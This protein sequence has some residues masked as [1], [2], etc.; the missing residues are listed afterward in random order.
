MM[1]ENPNLCESN[2]VNEDRRSR[3][4]K[5]GITQDGPL[6]KDIG[7]GVRTNAIPPNRSQTYTTC[8]HYVRR[9]KGA[10]EEEDWLMLFLGSCKSTRSFYETLHPYGGCFTPSGE[11]W[12]DI[13]EP[14]LSIHILLQIEK[15]GTNQLLYHM[16]RP[17]KDLNNKARIIPCKLKKQEAFQN[18]DIL[19]TVGKPEESLF[20]SEGNISC[21]N[22]TM[23]STQIYPKK[24]WLIMWYDRKKR[25]GVKEKD[26]VDDLGLLFEESKD[27]DYYPED[28]DQIKISKRRKMSQTSHQTLKGTVG[29]KLKQV[30]SCARG[31]NSLSKCLNKAFI[32]C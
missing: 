3:I 15:L 18:L 1:V 5:D 26:N 8:L 10:K 22:K 29:R 30:L 28:P 9:R 31:M 27:D 25:M 14:P 6:K 16:I 23:T 21:D 32:V 17:E 13:W 24:M 11:A 19:L 4:M 2:D 20:D 7:G 12:F